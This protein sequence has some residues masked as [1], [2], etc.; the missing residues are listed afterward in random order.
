MK[1]ILNKPYKIIWLSI[2]LVIGLSLIGL[3]KTIDIQMHDTYLVISLFHVGILFSII[4]G[5]IGFFYWLMR[6][7]KLINWM[8]VV[9]VIITIGSFL[10]ILIGAMLA[11]IFFL[12]V[13]TLTPL[14]SIILIG[15]LSQLLFL[16]NLIFSSIRNLEKT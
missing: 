8:T 11:K 4:L 3:N 9:H 6:K 15:L 10:I 1:I 16:F 14:S 12:Q 5:V 2:P 13:D 7:K